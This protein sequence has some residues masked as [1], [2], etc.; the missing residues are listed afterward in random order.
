MAGPPGSSEVS[1]NSTLVMDA[2]GSLALAA[3]ATLVPGVTEP[4]EDGLVMLTDG[5]CCAPLQAKPLTVK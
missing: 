5:T 1:K 3:T 2:V 4:P